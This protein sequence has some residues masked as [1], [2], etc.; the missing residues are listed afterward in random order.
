MHSAKLLDHFQH[1]RNV[2]VLASPA[3]SISVLNPA[4]GDELRLSV[5]WDGDLAAEVRFQV[6][7]CVAA[8]GTAS[9]LTQL[10]QGRTRADLASL[11]APDIESA[12][13]GL[14]NETRHAAALCLDAV[15]ALLK[16]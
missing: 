2:G 6:R 14:T 7:G 4:C 12:V 1:P 10:L 15:H 9:A 13:D 16:T 5:R 3:I 8:I 11:Q